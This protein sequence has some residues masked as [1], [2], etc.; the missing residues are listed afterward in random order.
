MPITSKASCLPTGRSPAAELPRNGRAA[1][2][3][4]RISDE[5]VRSG[6]SSLVQ[7]LSALLPSASN[8]RLNPV[9]SDFKKLVIGEPEEFQFDPR[10]IEFLFALQLKFHYEQVKGSKIAAAPSGRLG[11]T[12]LCGVAYLCV[13]PGGKLRPP[14]NQPLSSP[15]RQGNAVVVLRLQKVDSCC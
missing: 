13:M 15:R 2:T 7:L 8:F 12:P 6:R 10:F 3:L 5:W 11:G 14:T 4:R 1:R 9:R